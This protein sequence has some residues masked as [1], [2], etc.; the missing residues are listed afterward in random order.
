MSFLK[1]K[2]VKLVGF[3]TIPLVPANFVLFLR[4]RRTLRV[5]IFVKD[6]KILSSLGGAKNVK[7][8]FWVRGGEPSVSCPPLHMYDL[9]GTSY[10]YRVRFGW[11]NTKHI[12]YLQGS[13]VVYAMP[14][15]QGVIPQYNYSLQS[16][17]QLA[18]QGGMP[19]SRLARYGDRM[20][21][22]D[23]P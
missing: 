17:F 12:K 22:L 1:G 13:K 14:A 19:W 10:T 16:P 7:Y 5:Y 8:K 4:A 18:L 6:G 2:W 23:L 20:T 21:T 11:V 3:C 15:L 9:Q